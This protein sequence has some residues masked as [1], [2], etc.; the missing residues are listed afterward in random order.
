M[1]PSALGSLNGF[2]N[3]SLS[4]RQHANPR[5][6]VGKISKT[7]AGK[8]AAYL[9]LDPAATELE[10]TTALAELAAALADA[11]NKPVSAEVVSAINARLAEQDPA[12]ATA[13]ASAD[14]TL[15]QSIAD[16]AS[17]LSRTA[18]N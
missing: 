3:A 5:S 13:L 11:S 7:Y 1:H 2:F 4:A 14:P 15:D 6:A 16:T 8:L 9:G 10:R 12:L 18:P 17:A